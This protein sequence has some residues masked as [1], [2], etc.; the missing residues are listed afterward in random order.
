MG[1]KLVTVKVYEGICCAPANHCSIQSGQSPL[2]FT[3]HFTA[4][5][6]KE[7]NYSRADGTNPLEN[8]LTVPFT[9]GAQGFLNV[10][11]VTL[12]FIG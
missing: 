8:P 1:D 10:D 4:L 12:W 11:W 6:K 9:N 7:G 2:S 3:N 5:E